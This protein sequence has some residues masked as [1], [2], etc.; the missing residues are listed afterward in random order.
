MLEKSNLSKLAWMNQVSLYRWSDIQRMFL[1]A[2][3]YGLLAR[4]VL[5]FSTGNGNVT[6]FWIPGGLALAALLIWGR[7][8]WPAVFSGA[9]AAGLM[10]NDPLN[11]SFFIALGNTLESLCAVWLI[12]KYAGFDISFEKTSDFFRLA[13]I[14]AASSTISAVTGPTALILSGYLTSQFFFNNMLH[15]WQADVLGIVLCTPFFLI[16]R[17]PPVGWLIR[18]NITETLAIF[19]SCF[20]VGQIIFLNW[21]RQSIDSISQEYWMFLFV[22]LAAVRRGRHGALLVICMVAIQALLGATNGVGPFASDLKDTGLQNF[23][24]YLLILTLVGITLAIYVEA[25]KASEA[26]LRLSQEGGGIGS[27]E[28]DLVNNKQRWSENCTALLGFPS[29][30]EPRWEDFLAF[31]HPEDRQS[32]I[33]ATHLHIDYGKPYIVEY[34]ALNVNGEIRWMRSAGSL[35]RDDNGK[36]SIM[37]GIVQ[38]ITER[39]QFESE[40]AQSEENFRHLFNLM[41]DPTFIVSLDGKFITVN[42]AACESLGYSKEELLQMGPKFIDTPRFGAK[43][44]DRMKMLQEQGEGVFESEHARK[45][46]VVIPVEISCRLA[47]LSGNTVIIAVARDLSERKHAEDSQ[48]N[49]L[50]QLQSAREDERTRISREIHDEFGGLL[51]AIKLRIYSFSKHLSELNKEQRLESA[52]I[53]NLIDTAIQSVRKISTELRPSILDNLGLLPAIEW[54]VEEF[55][56]RSKISCSLHI[57]EDREDVIVDSDRTTAIFRILQESLTNIMRHSNA[58]QANIEVQY[59]DNEILVSIS[60]NGKGIVVDEQGKLG[61][62]GLLGMSERATQFGGHLEITGMPSIGTTVKLH[63]PLNPRSI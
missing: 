13:A 56:R 26:H 12:Q 54:Y 36:P 48:R 30:S 46:G 25:R 34:R 42:R 1:L 35:Q 63:M 57:P 62:L 17:K 7:N 23:W 55:M 16:W 8:Y 53:E 49:V 18:R 24:F 44:P 58:T 4:M 40:L 37:R 31:V 61:T 43:V 32:V 3:T 6:I 28:A 41:P 52:T 29:V 14:A 10:V 9:I 20:L 15:W 51:A 59:L 21:F 5:T 39:K 2:I 47:N 11:V 19:S 33:D 45:D 60:D 38:D 27:W 50:H 22:V